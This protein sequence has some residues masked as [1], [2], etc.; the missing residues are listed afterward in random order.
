MISPA[1]ALPITISDPDAPVP[2][3]AVELVA[4]L[5]L[6]AVESDTANT[7]GDPGGG[8]GG[9]GGEGGKGGEEPQRI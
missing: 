7:P 6:D 9:E 8:A 5:L 2:D 4:S 1:P 3:E